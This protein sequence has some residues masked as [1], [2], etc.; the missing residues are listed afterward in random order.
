MIHDTTKNKNKLNSCILYKKIGEQGEY[1][2]TFKEK[3]GEIEFWNGSNNFIGTIPKNFLLQQNQPVYLHQKSTK[4]FFNC[5]VLPENHESYK[6]YQYGV[7]P[8]E[9][10]LESRYDI[11]CN[12]R[13]GKLNNVPV[14]NREYQD[15]FGLGYIIIK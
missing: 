1:L 2:G 11:L 4:T 7:L 5:F 10:I 12:M 15:F 8:N 14:Y 13:D 6:D 9:L 3:N